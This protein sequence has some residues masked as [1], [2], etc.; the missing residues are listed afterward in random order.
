MLFYLVF[1]NISAKNL[2]WRLLKIKSVRGFTTLRTIL[3][4][5]KILRERASSSETVCR[6]SSGFN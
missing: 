1:N 5:G 2:F 4:H 6:P 3:Y